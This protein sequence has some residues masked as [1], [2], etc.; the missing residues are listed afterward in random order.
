M[1]ILLLGCIWGTSFIL[2]KKAN[3]VFQPLQVAGF[4]L[5]LAGL[6]LLPWV[7]KYSFVNPRDKATEKRIISAKDYG[8][9]FLSGFIGNGIPALLFAYAG[10]LIPSGLSGILNAL[11]PMFTVIIGALLFHVKTDRNGMLGVALGI[12][13]TAI[14]LLPGFFSGDKH[15]HMG[16]ALMALSA[17]VMYGYNINLIKSRLSHLPAMVKTAYPFLFM[18]LPYL[19][20]LILTNVVAAWD[21]DPALAWEA[22][23]FV[24][25][26]GVLGSAISMVVFNILIKYTNAL[27][28]STNTFI[29]PIAAIM[30]GLADGERFGVNIIVGLVL[31][32]FAIWLIMK[33]S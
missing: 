3:L 4:R 13:G 27:V 5:F 26:L 20:I 14:I 2:I 21:K 11:T 19:L 10:T 7:M 25:I 8:N 29:I 24:C 9:L 16:G 33:K 31:S 15:I 23:W 6:V 1:V 30:W 18:A 22:F 12:T 32:L 28:A 17:A